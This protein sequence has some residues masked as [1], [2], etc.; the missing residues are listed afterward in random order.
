MVK[1]K[2]EG[3]RESLLGFRA[4]KTKKLDVD[5]RTWE[6]LSMGDAD[7]AV[8]FLHGMGGAYDIWWQQ[9]MDL[10]QGL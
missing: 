4:F 5:G 6:Y 3:I 10:K 9:M 8:L 7:S 1:T 2:V